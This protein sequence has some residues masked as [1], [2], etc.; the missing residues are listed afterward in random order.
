MSNDLTFDPIAAAQELQAAQDNKK[1]IQA[2]YRKP[3]P[4]AV[5]DEISVEVAP[6]APQ[7]V[8]APH[9]PAAPESLTA[10]EIQAIQTA[11][12]ALTLAGL[13]LENTKLRIYLDHEMRTN[14]QIEADGRITRV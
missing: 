12:Q 8:P 6:L 4:V 7:A 5:P 14:D 3:A 2:K 11:Q 1:A 10:P 9:S 13:A